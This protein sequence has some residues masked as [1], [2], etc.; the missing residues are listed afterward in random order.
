MR[1]VFNFFECKSGGF[2][3]WGALLAVPLL[4]AV[5]LG[6]NISQQQLLKTELQSELDAAVLAGTAPGQSTSEELRLET[7]YKFVG[8]QPS[9][10]QVAQET[11]VE[12]DTVKE[13]SVDGT[14]VSGRTVANLPNLFAG[15]L[16]SEFMQVDV[17][18]KAVKRKS[19]PVCILAL[20][21]AEQRSI[22]V[23]GNAKVSAPECA[24]M[25]NSESG[26]GLKQYGKDSSVH[27]AQIGVTGSYDGENFTPLP[28][29]DVAPYVDPLAS[30]PIPDTGT[31]IDTGSKLSSVEITLDPGTYCGG[32]NISPQSRIT[33]SPGIYIMKDGPLRIGAG[34]S[35]EGVEVMI[36]LVGENSILD[37]S[38]NSQI[39]LTSP[40][41][42][43]YANIQIMSDR[44]ADGKFKGEEW[45]TISSSTV[46]L[47]GVVYLP[48]QDIWFKGGSQ[49]KANSP[50]Q[51]FI[52][53]QLWVQDTSDIWVTSLNSR[54]LELANGSSGFDY[55]ATLVD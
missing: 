20:N 42:G 55:G 18:S 50:T 48:E 2:A 12:I 14:S 54:N 28:Q 23:Y 52:A 47:D 49:I 21:P 34:S 11:Q 7:S 53:D 6:I 45:S 1:A 26:E 32:L 40:K 15:L 44:V 41:L 3:V 13:F 22:E 39:S 29:S 30:L 27:A 35:V 31:C 5:G 8:Y 38:A 19:K 4:G 24:I 37:I 16:G 36:A 10:F 17:Q 33:L 9:S 46:E 51:A 25:A 43:T